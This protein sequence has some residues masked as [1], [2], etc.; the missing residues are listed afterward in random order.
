MIKIVNM[1]GLFIFLFAF[2]LVSVRI[3]AQVDDGVEIISSPSDKVFVYPEDG[4]TVYSEQQKNSVK[5]MFANP[6][7]LTKGWRTFCEFA[8]QKAVNEYTCGVIDLSVLLG[9]QFN[10]YFFSGIGVGEQIYI[11]HWYYGYYSQTPEYA[12]VL[13]LFWDFRV[14]VLKRKITPFIDFRAGYSVTDDQYNNYSGFYFSPSVGVRLWKFNLSAGY[15]AVKLDKAWEFFD[16]RNNSVSEVF[17]Q[18]SYMI[19]LSYDFGGN[20]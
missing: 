18:I 5:K 4:V 17:Y 1:K 8:V 7:L 14:D 16:V 2:L 15:E 13:P 11:D 6:P 20:F 12:L 10:P 19:K 3:T 9:W